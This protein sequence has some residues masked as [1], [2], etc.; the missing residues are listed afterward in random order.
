MER[1][2]VILIRKTDDLS[3]DNL[4]KD[5]EEAADKLGS[6]IVGSILLVITIVCVLWNV[7]GKD[8][9]Q[10]DLEVEQPTVETS[11]AVLNE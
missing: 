9:I 7:C 11:A 3:K 8:Q 2:V 5:M 4:V 10:V 6:Y 1:E